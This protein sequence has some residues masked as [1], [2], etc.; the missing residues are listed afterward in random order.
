MCLLV[1]NTCAL[2]KEA[3]HEQYRRWVG[4][5]PNL[6]RFIGSGERQFIKVFHAKL[7]LTEKQFTLI[8]FSSGARSPEVEGGPVM[9]DR[10][11]E[12]CLWSRAA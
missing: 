8:S 12:H 6:F 4:T 2:S 10:S 5:H 9:V 3:D 1:E 7:M 11:T